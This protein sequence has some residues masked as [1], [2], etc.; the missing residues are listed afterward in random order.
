M[1]ELFDSS[2]YAYQKRRIEH[3]DA[4]AH[5]RDHWQGMGRW[6][7]QRLGQVFKFIV[8]PSQRILEIGC[9]KGDLLALLQPS[10][11]VGVDFSEEMIERAR[12][13]HPDLQFIQ[14]DAHDL[15]E[16]Q[17][18]FDF[19]ILSDLINDLWDVQRVFEQL[20][21]LCHPRTRL[22]INVYS[23]LWQF[24]LGL[25][26]TLSLANP[27]LDQ[28]WLTREDVNNMLQLAGFEIIHIT[29]EVL[30]PLPLGGFANRFLVRFPLFR[31]LALTNFFVARP[32]PGRA[33]EPKVSVM[34][35]ARNESG[36]IQAIFE[37]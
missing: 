37:R 35:P 36:N 5:K 16:I 28:N 32:L 20:V 2:G 7:H 17:E 31:A 6:Y 21:P 9:G 33:A 4:V 22:L 29:Q 11:G 13:N 34:I 1:D 10:H 30:W 8:V 15:T 19:I 24:P 18:T 12:L 14:A 26:Q 3:W 25:A 23:H 27:T